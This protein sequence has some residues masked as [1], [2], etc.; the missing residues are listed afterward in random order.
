MPWVS[1]DEPVVDLEH[2]AFEVAPAH[3]VLVVTVEGGSHAD[4]PAVPSE[5]S[6]G[7]VIAARGSV[8]G[9]ED[10]TGAP[11]LDPGGEGWSNGGD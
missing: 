2:I 11:V 6:L 1:T 8:V 3:V 9:T 10:A 7:G 5:Q 4:D